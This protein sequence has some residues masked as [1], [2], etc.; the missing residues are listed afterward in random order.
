MTVH[1]GHVTVMIVFL[2]LS[3]LLSLPPPLP[4]PPLP[5]PPLPPP[6]LP[7]PDPPSPPSPSSAVLENHHVAHSFKLTQASKEVNIYQNLDK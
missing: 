6:L 5:P 1:D 2:L 7:P 4:P 3:L